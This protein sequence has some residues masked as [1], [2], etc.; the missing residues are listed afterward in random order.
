MNTTRY[1]EPIVILGSALVVTTA[2]GLGLVVGLVG[3]DRL[4]TA[5]VLA[6]GYGLLG[7][8]LCGL[9]AWS[10]WHGRDSL[11]RRCRLGYRGVARE[12]V[13]LA[14]WFRSELLD[15]DEKRALLCLIVIGA[16]VRG[17]F[18]AQP[19]RFDEAKT[20]LETVAQAW[21]EL[22][23][24][25]DPNNHLLHSILARLTTDVLGSHPASLR[26]VAA[27]AGMASIP[28]VFVLARVLTGTG[29]AGLVAAALMTVH[30]HMLLVDTM[31]RGYS[32]KVLLVLVSSVL[33]FR[34]REGSSLRLAVLLAL[35]LGLGCLVMPSFLMPAIGLLA[36]AGLNPRTFDRNARSVEVLRFSACVALTILFTVALYTPTIVASMGVEGL[37]GNRWVSPIPFN[38]FLRLM[39]AHGRDTLARF[40]RDVPVILVFV[41][42]ASALFGFVRLLR[43]GRVAAALLFP[44]ILVAGLVVVAGKSAVPFSRTWTYLIPLTLVLVDCGLGLPSRR[45]VRRTVVVAAAL[46]AALLVSHDTIAK[47]PDTGD[48][49][50]ARVVAQFLKERLRPDDLV[51]SDVPAV[52]PLRFYLWYLEAPGLDPGASPTAPRLINSRTPWAAD[53]P[54]R[55]Y[56]VIKKSR[57][58]IR[59]LT[60][61][62][63]TLLFEVG[64]AAVYAG[65][66]SR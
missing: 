50:E 29:G 64:D 5:A 39:P 1:A 47:Y 43:R 3:D 57:Y 11:V 37:F 10:A 32:L 58:S 66:E 17:Y 18:L 2:A 13:D 40:V 23:A 20:F 62:P 25:H 21:P 27:I 24:Y 19:M 28:A 36:W 8:P 30:P 14:R 33:C 9:S 41:G 46:S 7:L 44:C 53:F 15:P 63:A 26:L 60:E 51:I 31:A 59:D 34:W 65:A 16:G 45:L 55:R 56:Y 6:V 61:Q 12:A 4:A 35:C 54:R 49:T 38:E 42:G 52:M 48:F 22:L